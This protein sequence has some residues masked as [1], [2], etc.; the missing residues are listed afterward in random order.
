MRRHLREQE[1]GER[2]VDCGNDPKPLKPERPRLPHRAQPQEE[3]E[4]DDDGRDRILEE[5]GLVVHG[6]GIGG[7]RPQCHSESRSLEHCIPVSIPFAPSEA[8]A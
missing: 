6:A 1:D 4:A 8:E 5:I 7:G 3:D 2:E